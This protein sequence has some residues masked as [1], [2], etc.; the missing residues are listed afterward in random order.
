[1]TSDQHTADT[2]DMTWSLN[3]L[4]SGTPGVVHAL[5]ISS[6]GLVLAASEGLERA[7]AER[8]A[9]ALSGIKALQGDLGGL[10]GIPD[11]RQQTSPLTLRHVVSDLK[12]RTVLLFAAG[13]RTG[14][15]VSVRGDSTSRECGLA[16]T[17]TL[18]LIT[19]LRPVLEARERTGGA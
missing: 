4:V 7:D 6:D 8:A 15:G 11:D 19:G 12:E 3:Q 16:I 14:L 1:M 18:K 17:A 5:L 9:A 2:T 13:T 10:C